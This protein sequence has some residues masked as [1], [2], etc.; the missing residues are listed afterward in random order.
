MLGDSAAR[1]SCLVAAAA[2]LLLHQA[3]LSAETLLSA[4][5]GTSHTRASGLRITQPGPGTDLTARDVQWDA[6][7]LR[8]APYYGLRLTHFFERQASWGAALDFTHY[9]VYA[10]TGRVVSTNGIW[11]GAP[12]ASAAPLNRYVQ[13]FEISHGVNVVSVNGIY[14]W[15]DPGLAAGRLQPYLGA[16]LAYY[17]LHAENTVGGVPHQSGYQASGFG[18][19]LLAGAHYRLTERMGLFAETKF[20]RGAA[21]VEVAGGRAQTPLRT[22]HVVGGVSFSF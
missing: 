13:R 10:K 9:K 17:V 7:P 8:P 11:Q 5:T 12:V 20:D 4:Y 14:R 16:G 18:Y 3:P 15:L 6:D 1:M 22:F 21:Q 19:Q 2:C